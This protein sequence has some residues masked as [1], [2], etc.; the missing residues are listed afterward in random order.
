MAGLFVV[1]TGLFSSWKRV[2]FTP[3]VFCFSSNP[4]IV[5][6]CCC[7]RAHKIVILPLDNNVDRAFQLDCLYRPGRSQSSHLVGIFILSSLACRCE[8]LE[9]HPWRTKLNR[10]LFYDYFLRDLFEKRK[11]TCDELSRVS[12]SLRH[13]VRVWWIRDLYTWFTSGRD[14]CACRGCLNNKKNVDLQQHLPVCFFR[15]FSARPFRGCA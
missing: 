2:L 14:K 15:S 1:I 8:T 4:C 10:L 3:K 11:N 12:I 13:F 5:R 6:I 7:T 9:T